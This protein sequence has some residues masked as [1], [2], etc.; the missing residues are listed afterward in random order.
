MA[1]YLSHWTRLP[2]LLGPADERTQGIDFP[3]ELQQ[4]RLETLITLVPQNGGTINFKLTVL[5]TQCALQ[6]ARER[7]NGAGHCY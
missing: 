5:V 4:P 1:D 3:R 6:D 7:T 2:S